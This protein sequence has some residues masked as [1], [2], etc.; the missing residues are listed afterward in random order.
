MAKD[1]M[2]G[3]KAAPARR[4]AR[5]QVKLVEES[6]AA[7]LELIARIPRSYDYAVEPALTF[8]PLLGRKAGKGSR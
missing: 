2:G 5:D 8:D 1:R 7:L 6:A 4:S 3:G